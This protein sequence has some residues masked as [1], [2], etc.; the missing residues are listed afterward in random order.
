M[1]NEGPKGRGLGHVNYL[2]ILGFLNNSGISKAT[3]CLKVVNGDDANLRAE[4]SSWSRAV[5][6]VGGG[7]NGGFGGFAPRN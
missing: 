4:L 6:I 1:Q 2:S 7:W 5:L 3:N